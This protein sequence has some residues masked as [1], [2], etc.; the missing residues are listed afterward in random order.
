MQSL[1]DGSPV[2]H[3]TLESERLAHSQLCDIVKDLSLAFG[4]QLVSY[5]FCVFLEHLARF[6]FM[7][8]HP[9][10]MSSNLDTANNVKA[11]QPLMFIVHSWIGVYLIAY[12]SDKVTESSKDIITSLRS[13]PIWKL[14]RCHSTQIMLFMTQVQ[15]SNTEVTA[16]G[17][18]KVNKTILSS[19]TMSLATY[20]IVVIQLSPNIK[21][22]FIN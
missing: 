14:P 7:T 20:I 1:A 22:I 15:C 11:L 12:L 19:I 10:S 16:C 2:S 5:L 8:Y 9:E 3:Q 13:I 17:L 21:Q 6:Y 18:F 4:P